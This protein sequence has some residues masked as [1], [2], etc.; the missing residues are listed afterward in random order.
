MWRSPSIRSGDRAVLRVRRADR[1]PWPD[2]AAAGP[3]AASRSSFAAQE[4]WVWR[5]QLGRDRAPGR[6][7]RTEAHGLAAPGDSPGADAGRKHEGIAMAWG[8][9]A[10]SGAGL[11]PFRGPGWEQSLT[12]GGS[13]G[14]LAPGEPGMVTRAQRRGTLSRWLSARPGNFGTTH[15]VQMVAR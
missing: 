1:A 12:F 2:R 13:H 4:C 15:L 3:A 9:A 6:R 7:D 8:Y 10:L 5:R 14:Y 11:E